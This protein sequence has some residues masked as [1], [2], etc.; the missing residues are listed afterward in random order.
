MARR[1]PGDGQCQVTYTE[2]RDALNALEQRQ[3]DATAQ[4]LAR[5]TDPAELPDNVRRML[6]T[7]ND[8][9]G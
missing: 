8:W 2:W 1:G 3:R 7:D 5:V 9:E 4:R 6:D